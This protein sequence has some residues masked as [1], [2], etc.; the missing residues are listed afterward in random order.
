MLNFEFLHFNQ[1]QTVPQALLRK[2]IFYAREHCHPKVD[3]I[4][5][6]KLAQLYVDLRQ[7]SSVCTN[8]IFTHLFQISS[9]S[10]YLL[11]V[12]LPLVLENHDD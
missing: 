12:C 9:V 3:N 10:I 8:E 4:D 11:A 5:G 2:Y 7:Q 6:H 1:L